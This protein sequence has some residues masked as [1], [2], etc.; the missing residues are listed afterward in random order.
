MKNATLIIL[1]ISVNIFA[2]VKAPDTDFILKAGSVYW[3]HVYEVPGKATAEIT[4]LIEEKFP[5]GI[6]RENFAKS[7]KQITFLVKNDKPNIKKMGGKETKTHTIAL[8]Y[9]KYQV[10]IDIQDGRYTATL[11]QIFLDNLDATERKSGDISKFA[12]NTSN[13]TFK[14]DPGVLKGLVYDHMHFL[15]KFDINIKA[16]PETKR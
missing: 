2:Q 8:L 9:M 14:T 12:C 13:L 5:D 7:E 3:Q 10:T 11:R 1:F 15:Q 6:N 4:Q 16:E